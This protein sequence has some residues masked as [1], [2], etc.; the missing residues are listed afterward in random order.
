MVANYQRVES[1]LKQLEVKASDSLVV[2]DSDEV[3]KP[4][5]FKLV[6]EHFKTLPV[7]VPKCFFDEFLKCIYRIPRQKKLLENIR[8]RGR[9][10]TFAILRHDYNNVIKS[11]DIAQVRS[12][13]QKYLFSDHLFSARY[14]CLRRS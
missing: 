4:E 11:C 2:K 10:R 13:P 7:L 14:F 5:N 6:S 12:P 1:N 9:D 3:P 8:F